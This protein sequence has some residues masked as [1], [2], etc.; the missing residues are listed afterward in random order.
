MLAEIWIWDTEFEESCM[1]CFHVAEDWDVS[2][3][4]SLICNMKDYGYDYREGNFVVTKVLCNGKKMRL[5]RYY[6]Y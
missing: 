4:M 3:A 5:P 6:E 1:F 2:G